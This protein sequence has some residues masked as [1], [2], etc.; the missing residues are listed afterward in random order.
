MS[1][2]KKFPD[3]EFP[4]HQDLVD[5]PSKGQF[6][7][8][9][10][11]LYGQSCVE[12]GHI[13]GPE[14][15]I[16]TNKDYLRRDIAVDKLLQS[17]IVNDALKDDKVYNQLLIA[18]Q[19][20]MITKA[21]ITAYTYDYACSIR[22][23]S[24]R[25]TSNFVFDLRKYA[26]KYPDIAADKDVSYDEETNQFI[27]NIPNTKISLRILPYTVDTQRKI[28]AK[29][30]AKKDKTLTKKERYEDVIFSINEETDRKYVAEFFKV[31][32]AFY[33][34]WL[35]T[36]IE[37][38]NIQISFEQQFVCKS[39]QFEQDLEP[40]FTVDFLYTPKMNRK[41]TSE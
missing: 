16:L 26:V 14:E 38:I 34:K 19:L 37:D 33:L 20:A 13:R 8:K 35:E 32:P 25:E 17:L 5:L 4:V 18:D 21:R 24:C 31:A 23:P 7:A 29:L 10:H 9:D 28:K 11:P 41:K 36:V 3:L 2:T 6:Y 12:I 27:V 1:S 40:P 30:L 39:C 22:C 15:D